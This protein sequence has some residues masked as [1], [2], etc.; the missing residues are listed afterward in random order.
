MRLAGLLLIVALTGNVLAGNKEIQETF[1]E[2]RS[3]LTSPMYRIVK[4]GLGEGEKPPEDPVLVA[5]YYAKERGVPFPL[6]F[7]VEFYTDSTR[8]TRFS[9]QEIV[10]KD[11]EEKEMKQKVLVLKILKGLNPAG[12]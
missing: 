5:C 2:F 1:Q 3:V 10:A 7:I 6:T 4:V 9:K 11:C 8:A 12:M